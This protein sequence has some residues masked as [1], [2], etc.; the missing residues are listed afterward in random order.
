MVIQTSS[1]SRSNIAAQSYNITA[2]TPDLSIIGEWVSLFLKPCLP[3]SYHR[4]TSTCILY[5]FFFVSREMMEGTSVSP[6]RSQTLGSEGRYSSF[7]RP[8]STD[9]QKKSL[10]TKGRKAKKVK[11]RS[12]TTNVVDLENLLGSRSSPAQNSHQQEASSKQSVSFDESSEDRASSVDLNWSVPDLT[13]NSPSQNLSADN[14]MFSPNDSIST[15]NLVQ[16]CCASNPDLLSDSTHEHF[17]RRVVVRNKSRRS[18]QI[19]ET[20]KKPASPT[21]TGP[22]TC[23]VAVQVEPGS[24]VFR[25]PTPPSSLPLHQNSPTHSLTESKN[26][27]IPKQAD[28]KANKKGPTVK[29][30]Q[31]R[32]KK[33][34]SQDTAPSEYHSFI[35]EGGKQEKE[36][37]SLQSDG[38]LADHVSTIQHQSVP[39]VLHICHSSS[40]LVFGRF[41]LLLALVIVR[42]RKISFMV[43][44]AITSMAMSS[45]HSHLQTAD[46]LVKSVTSLTDEVARLK[47]HQLLL[48]RQ[49]AVSSVILVH[50]LLERVLS[51]FTFV[52]HLN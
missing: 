20:F 7:L 17:Y 6:S 32:S 29:K 44:L 31:F 15:T 37:P 50:F 30:F 13:V 9:K 35:L 11:R 49:N 34:S 33:S 21:G 3:P 19:P 18:V 27:R 42:M 2:S 39:S 52:P 10:F 26:N 1:T 25:F 12:M 23:D 24:S 45:V 4:V 47:E 51:C 8:E 48:Y 46:T 38:K 5:V 22:H 16:M 28:K 36:K 41:C 43:G 40:F 14:L